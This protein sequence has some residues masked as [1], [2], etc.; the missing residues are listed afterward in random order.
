VVAAT[1][2]ASLGVAPPAQAVPPVDAYQDYVDPE[3][4]D[5][6]EQ[7]GVV[8]YRDMLLSRVGGES[9]GIHACSGYEHGEGRAFDWMMDAGNADDVAKVD[10]VLNWLL[11]TDAEGNPHAMARRLGIGNIIWNHRSI[12]LWTDSEKEWNDYE[13]DGTPGGCHT[14]HVHFAFSWAG[15]RQETTWF[16]TPDRP[17]DWYPG[18]GPPP[19]PPP[20]A[21]LTF[22]LSDD[23]TSTQ[24][25]RPAFAYGNRPM[26]PIVGDWDGDGTDTASTY[27]PTTAQ[28]FISNDP[29][30]GAAQH[31]FMYGNPGA[32]PL[33]GDWD[34]DGRD[35]VGVRMGFT[36]FLRTSAVDDPTE[37]TATVHYGNADDVPVIGDWD[38]DGT[39]NVGVY[40]PAGFRFHLRTTANSD[41]TETTTVVAYGNPNAVP[42]VGDWNG[43][44]RDNIGVRMGNVFY[45]RADNDQPET[46]TSVAYGNGVGNE[47]PVVGDWNGDGTDTQG[48]VFWP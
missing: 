10:Q 26:V 2:L 42:L 30:T 9:G 22:A 27:D 25:T 34:G 45:F 14:N 13:C 33:V 46:T 41:P 17:A 39:D 44:G 29:T 35:N 16:T 36:F 37:T 48:M 11:A 43:D 3:C 23:V 5:H 8:E 4:L 20:P 38:G 47:Q 6:V 7:P 1:V 32:A 21:N 19:P 28:F 15:A 31:T 40:R 12:S 24:H 18:G